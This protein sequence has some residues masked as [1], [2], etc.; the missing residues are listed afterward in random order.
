[1]PGARAGCCR[2]R[3]CRVNRAEAAGSYRREGERHDQHSEDGSGDPDAVP[4]AHRGRRGRGDDRRAAGGHHRSAGGGGRAVPH[5]AAPAALC[6][7]AAR[8]RA[9]WSGHRG[10]QRHARGGDQPDRRQPGAHRGPGRRFAG[11][12]D[13]LRPAPRNA[14]VAVR[15]GRPHGVVGPPAG[16]VR[17]R[18]GAGAVP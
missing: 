14:G 8:G 11:C 10:D 15:H 7:V 9:G 5:A 13:R 18:R 17:D 12:A 2:C 3:R 6:A 16:Q 4:R 1:M